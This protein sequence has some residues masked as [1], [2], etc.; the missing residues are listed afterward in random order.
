VMGLILANAHMGDPSRMGLNVDAWGLL[1]LAGAV[2]FWSVYGGA[3]RSEVLYR[4]RRWLGLAL[5][6]AMY[7]IFRRTT[8]SGEVGWIDGSY[9]EILGLIGY[10]YLAVCILYIPTRRWLWAPCAWFVALTAFCALT[11]ARWIVLPHH[12]PLYF[13]PFDNGAMAS[14]T[15]AGVIT[16]SIFLGTHRWQTARQ[17]MYLA[18]GFSCIALVAGWLLSP[19]GI[20]K[21]RATPTWCLYSIGGSI[22]L[23]TAL[24][25][26]C[27]VK[28]QTRWAFFAHSAGSNTL[29]TYLLPDFYHYI[30][31][32]IGFTY[33][34]YNFGWQG[35]VRS[36][37]FTA[38]ILV[39]SSILTK[40]KVRMQL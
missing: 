3:R 4:G 6:V 36:M 5:M 39:L 40:W 29:L 7:A 26:V 37:L 24:Y 15:M 27:D 10:T 16:S 20:S 14:I 18:A 21:D 33:L 23:F 25:W 35:V 28:K 17:K 22:L 2:L 11:A 12:L 38:A 1:G 19:L 8:H 30:V 31:G 13:F 9:P 32:W 34:S